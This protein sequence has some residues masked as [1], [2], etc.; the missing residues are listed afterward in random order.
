MPGWLR[1]LW[2]R[3]MREAAR[4]QRG[5]RTGGSHPGD[6]L[7]S[8]A[9]TVTSID[10]RLVLPWL[11][12]GSIASLGPSGHRDAADAAGELGHSPLDAAV[13][14]DYARRVSASPMS[15]RP[16][17]APW[18]SDLVAMVAAVASVGRLSALAQLFGKR[19][20]ATEAR[21]VITSEILMA[22]CGLRGVGASGDGT[23]AAAPGRPP[24]LGDAAEVAPEMLRLILNFRLPLSSVALRY[25]NEIRRQYFSPGHTAV[26]LSGSHG[27][28]IT[29]AAAPPPAKVIEPP[30]RSGGVVARRAQQSAA[31]ALPSPLSKPQPVEPPRFTPLGDSLLHLLAL[32]LSETG[33]PIPTDVDDVPESDL[34]RNMFRASAADYCPS[35]AH[36]VAL[37]QARRSA[38]VAEA[39][40]HLSELTST[41]AA[42]ASDRALEGKNITL[43]V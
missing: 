25:V 38:R 18:P 3:I 29:H 34:S 9:A 8:I 11:V 28:T 27:V 14:E 21:G 23:I 43:V 26:L 5:A 22:H 30:R 33:E 15:A 39:K 35:A 31:S 7:A 4:A 40:R 10:D 42:I 32:G 6:P 36:A 17:V 2:L 41:A 24:A 16:G 20:V 37:L 1:L 13:L 12:L 19:V